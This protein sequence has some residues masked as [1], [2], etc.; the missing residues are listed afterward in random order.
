MPGA[1]RLTGRERQVMHLLLQGES[2]KRI[3]RRLG[4]SDLTVRKH[5]EN[6]MRKLDV[7]SVSQLAALCGRSE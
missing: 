6:L 5:R 3:A 2:S 1:V 7:H 4:L